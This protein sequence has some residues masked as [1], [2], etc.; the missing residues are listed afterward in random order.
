MRFPVK[1]ITDR[2]FENEAACILLFTC[3]VESTLMPA[4]RSTFVDEAVTPWYH[5]ISRCVRRAFLCGQGYEYR[6]EWIENRL[7][8]LVGVFAVELAGFAIMDNHL[9]LLVRLDSTKAR[10][11]SVDEVVWR[12]LSVFPLQTLIARAGK[13]ASA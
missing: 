9:H 2:W 10:E 5:C 7:Q 11:W 3:K 13:A 6:K 8:E 4:P 1:I 12:W